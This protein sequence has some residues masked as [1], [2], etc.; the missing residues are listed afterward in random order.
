MKTRKNLPKNKLAIKILRLF[1]HWKIL[2]TNSYFLLLF[3]SIITGFGAGLAAV[4]IKNAVHF[5]KKIVIIGIPDQYT[6]YLYFIYPIIGIAL[7]VIFIHFILKQTVG[8][9]IPSILYAISQNQA[10][11]K[12]HNLYSSIITSA[13][14]VGFGG[15]VGLEGPTVATGGA[16]G[17]TI[18]TIFKLDYRQRI[19]LLGAA[20]AGAMSAIFKAPIAGVVF[21]LEV[22]MIDLTSISIIPILLA[23]VSG[24][25][26]SFMFLGTNYL[27]QFTLK[28][29]FHLN[30]VLY[31]VILGIFTGIVSAYFIKIYTYSEKFFQR[32]KSPWHRLFI[33]GAILGLLIFLFPALYGEGYP[34]INSA[35]KGDYSFL[36]NNSLF[37]KYSDN[38]IVI[39]L[40]FLAL[41]FFKP[42]ATS[43]TFGAGGIGG[44]FAPSLFIGSNLGLFIAMFAN[45][46]GYK[47]S[48]S[49]SA[50][51]GMAGLIA[52]VLHAPLTGIFL[53]GEITGGYELLMPL[54]I[55]AT[56]SYITVR[57][58]VSNNIYSIQLA[59]K[60]QLL[61][62][63]A[64]H[65]ILRMMK[66]EDIIEKDFIPVHP[67]DTLGDLVKAVTRSTRNLFP[68]IDEQNH[69]LGIV[70][71]NRIRKIMFKKELY[72]KIRV[73]EI[74]FIPDVVAYEDESIQEIAEKLQK[75]PIFNIVVLGR[76]KTYRGF[77]SRSNLFSQ[78]RELLQKFSAD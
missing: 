78:Y 46:I 70:S 51:V 27:Y 67:Q 3:L 71:M 68:V 54:M 28:D 2:G 58:F 76:D 18:G 12:P 7:S 25:L 10:F 34:T 74:M 65:N 33:G 35:L 44:I 63:H 59:E 22:I 21:A 77:I 42:I 30:Q 11:I 40:L 53:I 41:V 49:N 61:T 36:F 24:S 56:V 50:L 13:L 5:I 66:I 48:Y 31:F 19:L 55:T 29:M 16:V 57:L 9:G 52:G 38:I 15:S 45:Q 8:H 62:H 6:N 43:V 75:N 14:T 20:S 73:K 23:S 37:Y 72:D 47:I 26:T 17:S 4:I 39:T 64:D 69:F 32:L 60:K 1:V